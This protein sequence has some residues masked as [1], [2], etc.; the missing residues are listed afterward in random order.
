MGNKFLSAGPHSFEL[1]RIDLAFPSNQVRPLTT[2]RRS[3]LRFV[4][5]SSIQPLIN[6]C[7]KLKFCR[8]LVLL[9]IKPFL[10][11]RGLQFAEL[12]GCMPGSSPI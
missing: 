8:A 2:R 11:L 3:N 6:L 5:H 12:Y 9:S 1:C 10:E 4:F 7:V